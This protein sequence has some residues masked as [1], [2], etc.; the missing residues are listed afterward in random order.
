M[1]EEEEK[2]NH[3]PQAQV[4]PFGLSAIG[5]LRF[6]NPW[7]SARRSDSEWRKGE[8][9]RLGPGP[10]LL[11]VAGLWPSQPSG[12]SLH[13]PVAPPVTGDIPTEMPSLPA[14]TALGQEANGSWWSALH[15]FL[16]TEE[17]ATTEEKDSVC[18][19]LG[20]DSPPPGDLPITKFL[21]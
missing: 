16:T 10:L 2:G 4:D 5:C 9:G 17:G 18:P 8:V 21:R 20:P 7:N 1:Q 15:T 13:L 3:F 6:K 14:V 11:C 19:T 12:G